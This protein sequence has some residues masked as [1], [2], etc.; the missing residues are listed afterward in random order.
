MVRA[1]ISRDYKK[2]KSINDELME[3]YELL[4]AENNP[5]GVKAA[6]AELGIIE[7]YLRLP[8]VPLSQPLNSRLK[9][10]LMK[11]FGVKV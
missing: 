1:C 7:N 9:S 11:N 5:A 10:Y 6:L 8:L 2:A 3:G 4:F